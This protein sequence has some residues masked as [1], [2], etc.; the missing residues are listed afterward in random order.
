[1]AKTD[2]KQAF[3]LLP[4]RRE[5][6]PLLGI[7]WQGQYYVDKCLPFGLRSA[8]FLYNRTAEA[9]EWILKHV[10]GVKHII[11]YLDDF[12]IVGPTGSVQ[13]QK[14]LEAIRTAAELLGI[15]IAVEKTVGPTVV[16]VFLGIELDSSSGTIRLP[17]QNLSELMATLQA[18]RQRRKCTKRSLLSLIG[19]L[20]FAT[21]VVPAGWIF[22]RRLIDASMRAKHLEH[23][24][25]LTQSDRLDIEWWLEFLPTWSGASLFL[26]PYWSQ[27]PELQLFTDAAGSVGF[28][29]YFRGAWFNGKWLKH[30]ELTASGISIAWQ[31]MYAIVAAA[32]TWSPELQCKKIVF[33]TDNMSIMQAWK[34]RSSRDHK[35]MTLIRQLYLIAARGNFMIKLV[36]I[37][38]KTNEIAD[39]LS[40]FQVQR[41][42][43]LA[44]HAALTPTPIPPNIYTLGT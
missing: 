13:C 27:A 10:Y 6:W 39:A 31:E 17:H 8:P 38:G 5:D 15:P 20:S 40:R 3:R 7:K 2:I 23:H 12:F 25:S 30:Q 41:F 24:I 26:D 37:P 19:K 32:A 18:W 42:R 21:K 14:D 11:H 4:V 35:L 44:P 34:R 29:A 33:N 16:I 1:M 9:F 43:S 36:H 28:G 22:L